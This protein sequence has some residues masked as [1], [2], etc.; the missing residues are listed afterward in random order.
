MGE[1]GRALTGRKRR[2]LKPRLGQKRLTVSRLVS[3]AHGLIEVAQK[4]W[5]LLCEEGGCNP[6]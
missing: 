2:P 6:V 3:S 4:D 5:I 1:H